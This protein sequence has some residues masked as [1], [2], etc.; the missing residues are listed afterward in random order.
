MHR[1]AAATAALSDEQLMA[2]VQADDDR[3]FEVL[4]DRYH[5]RAWRLAQLLCRQ[6]DREDRVVEDAFIAAWRDRARY[7]PAQ[8]TAHTWT[9]RLLYRR[10]TDPHRSELAL[11]Q[12]GQSAT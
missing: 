6:D 5:D 11:D 7:R 1:T 10:A 12:P 3:A 4:Y 9:M 2:R 8:D